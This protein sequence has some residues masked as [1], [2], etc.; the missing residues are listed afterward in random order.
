MASVKLERENTTFV[1][2]IASDLRTEL[3]RKVSPAEVVNRIIDVVREEHWL[4]ATEPPDFTVFRRELPVDATMPDILPIDR[5]QE[6][7]II[8]KKLAPKSH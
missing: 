1:Q 8:N 3:G 5:L 7:R 4:F 2:R 6:V